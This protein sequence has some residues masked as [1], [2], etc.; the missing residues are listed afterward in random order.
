MIAGIPEGLF[1]GFHP[2]VPEEGGVGLY[3]VAFVVVV[4]GVDEFEAQVVPH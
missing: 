2:Q 3:G 1:T 4:G